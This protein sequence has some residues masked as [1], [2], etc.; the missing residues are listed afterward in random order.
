MLKTITEQIEQFGN[1]LTGKLFSP[2]SMFMLVCGTATASDIGMLRCLYS[3]QNSPG[4][5]NDA[6][7]LMRELGGAD[8]R[9]DL[10]YLHQPSISKHKQNSDFRDWT[11]LI[12]LCRDAWQAM[13][14]KSSRA[15]AESSGGLVDDPVPIVSPSGVFRSCTK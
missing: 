4:C 12:N 14:T 5:C 9:N 13:A 10:S 3:C 7:D 8:D 6:L 15:G 1:S 11:A 2:K